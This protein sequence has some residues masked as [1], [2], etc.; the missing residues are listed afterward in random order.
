MLNIVIVDAEEDLL[1]ALSK[2]LVRDLPELRVKTASSNTD[3]IDAL[4]AMRTD[5]LIT[6][7]RVSGELDSFN[8][9]LQAKELAPTAKLIV[10]TSFGS[11]DEAPPPSLGIARYINKPF[12]V[13]TLR[14]LI[15]GVIEER[16][17]F[18][19]AISE[20]GL[21]DILSLICLCKRT[22]RLHLNH[23]GRRGRIDVIDG[24]IVHAEFGP[25]RGVEAIY[26]MLGLRQGDIFMQS[27]FT[28]VSRSVDRPWTQIMGDAAE[29]LS[30]H[31]PSPDEAEVEIPV[32]GW[33]DESFELE[34]SGAAAE[35]LE[36][37]N[38]LG[39]S[40]EELQQI[41]I[42]EP[43]MA[44]T[45]NAPR[46]ETL[47]RT[48]MLRPTSSMGFRPAAMMKH[49]GSLSEAL[50]TAVRTLAEEVPGFVAVDI[51]MIEDGSSVA[52]LKADDAEDF[53][54]EL[55][56]VHVGELLRLAERA[57]AAME[58][59]FSALQLTSRGYHILA[60]RMGRS[61]YAQLVTLRR[62]GN[63]GLA[64]VLM[65]RVE[66]PLLAAMPS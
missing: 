22:I 54:Q 37:D 48:P 3:A 49:S 17:D 36:E 50:N 21:A 61:V 15:E 9:I 1:W 51:I 43:A 4:K 65:R 11:E 25:G 32:E 40:A 7:I 35:Y 47:P 38:P 55:T 46:E 42:E 58:G 64:T 24:A 41:A 59:E 53:D 27:D 13:Q 33:E 23:R 63:L 60:R 45:L 19:G 12:E 2:N 39:F 6:D 29:W 57:S 31:A 52:G 16:D 14:H 34:D 18:A 20:L 66:A 28:T 44:A 30:T 5:L 56:A 10:M 62:E 26:T 8:I